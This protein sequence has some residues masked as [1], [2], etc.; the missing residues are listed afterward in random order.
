MRYVE[1][2]QRIF[3]IYGK[4]VIERTYPIDSLLRV[5]HNCDM[6]FYVI[7]LRNVDLKDCKH[8]EHY[9]NG[10]EKGKCDCL[11][12][13]TCACDERFCSAFKCAGV[14]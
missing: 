5:I 2:G 9:L 12:D 14:V 3:A 4:D 8:C 7:T 6:S 1:Y 10:V 13:P 11:D